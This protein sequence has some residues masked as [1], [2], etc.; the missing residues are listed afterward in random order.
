MFNLMG[1]IHGGGVGFV[2]L[3]FVVAFVVAVVLGSRSQNQGS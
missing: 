2:F 1:H 3:I